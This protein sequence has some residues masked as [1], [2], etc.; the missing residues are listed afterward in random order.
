MGLR[1]VNESLQKD[2]DHLRRDMECLGKDSEN[3][4]KVNTK[5]EQIQKLE[6]ENKVLAERKEDLCRQLT[7]EKVKTCK[8]RVRAYLTEDTVR[9]Q[10]DLMERLMQESQDFIEFHTDSQVKELGKNL[11]SK[12]QEYKALQA[13]KGI[14]REANN[15]L[16]QQIQ[17]LHMKLQNEAN[18][19]A[20]MEAKK[21]S[22]RKEWCTERIFSSS[23]AMDNIEGLC[24][25]SEV[26]TAATQQEVT[27]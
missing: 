14:V 24:G 11:H 17:E 19:H 21:G 6:K 25:A 15:A 4:H 3:L 23:R 7:K 16:R 5:L 20:F 13:A 12:T 22:Q 26:N 9:L 10:N 27:D 2:N 18:S 8:K 1:Q